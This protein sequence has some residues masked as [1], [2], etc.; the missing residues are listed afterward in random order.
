MDQDDRTARAVV[1]VIKINFGGVFLADRDV[2]F[3]GFH[4]LEKG[5]VILR[6]AGIDTGCKRFGYGTS[7]GAEAVQLE[8]APTPCSRGGSRAS[9]GRFPPGRHRATR[10]P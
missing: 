7:T 6:L 10:S 5:W 4:R 1:F 8:F 3:R 9:E 2:G